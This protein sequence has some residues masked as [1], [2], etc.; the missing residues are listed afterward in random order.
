MFYVEFSMKVPRK[1][2]RLG[3][4]AHSIAFGS[5]EFRVGAGNQVAMY[6]ER[7]A[8]VEKSVNPTPY[9]HLTN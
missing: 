2:L 7:V 3:R 9:E 4:Q 1:Y 5:S 6:G 8:P